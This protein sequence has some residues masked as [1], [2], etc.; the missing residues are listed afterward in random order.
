MQTLEWCLELDV[1][2]VSVYAFSIEKFKRP[3]EDTGKRG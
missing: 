2:V 3:D 1:K